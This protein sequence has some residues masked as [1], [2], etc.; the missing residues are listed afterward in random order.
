MFTLV[1]RKALTYRNR[2]VG[3]GEPFEATAIDAAVLTYHRHAVFP[4][5]SPE[6][7]TPPVS[8]PADPPFENICSQDA[9]VPTETADEESGT[10]PIRKRRIYHRR[11]L[12]AEDSE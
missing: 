4:R 11:D 1:A 6:R 9:G 12:T 8:R 2:N 7:P 5:L 3:V 10:K